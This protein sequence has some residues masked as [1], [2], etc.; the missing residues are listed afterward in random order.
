MYPFVV[1]SVSKESFV[2]DPFPVN[3]SKTK[4]TGIALGFFRRN[5]VKGA[6]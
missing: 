6:A 5:R 2:S 4:Q 1:R 3:L